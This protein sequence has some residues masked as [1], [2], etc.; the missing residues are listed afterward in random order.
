MTFIVGLKCCDGI[1]LC[2]DSLEDDGITKKPVDKITRIQ[3]PHW[4]VAIGGSGGGRIIDKFCDEVRIHL[5]RLKFSRS[6]IEEAIEDILEKFHRK[7]VKTERDKF[8]VIVA[9]HGAPGDP[10]LL[11]EGSDRFLSPVTD[12]CHI[13][14]GNDI[15]RMLADILYDPLNCIADNLRLAIFATR[16]AIR[17]ASGVDA[18]IQA[19]SYTVGDQSW[20]VPN[21]ATVSR[22]DWELNPYDFREAIRGYWSTHNPP[23]RTEQVQKYGGV[24][25]PGDEITFLIGV[26]VEKLQ[27]VAGRNKN[28]G[29]LYGNRD[30]LRKRALLE[31]DLVQSQNKSSQP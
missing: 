4:G 28:E 18:P 11:Y 29:F 6:L 27:T 24:L 2:T 14:M 16:L 9:V 20:K 17:Y 1:V 26:A 25:A 12:E 15:W 13:G 22:I 3:T 19:V 8:E 10:L 31:Q 30:R 21:P 7:Y 5:P 23:T